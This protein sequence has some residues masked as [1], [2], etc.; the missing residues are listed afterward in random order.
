MRIRGRFWRIN[1]LVSALLLVSLALPVGTTLAEPTFVNN[2]FQAKW[3]RAD[4]P[5]QDGTVSP[6]RSWLWGPEGFNQPGAMTEPYAESPGGTRQVQYFDKARMELNNPA[7]ANVTNGLLV[8]ELISGRL[9]TGDNTSLARKPADIPVAGDAVNNDG[10][11]YASLASVAS[12]NLGKPSPN[13]TGQPVGDT[14]DKA[15]KT[16]TAPQLAAKAM[17]AYFDSVLKHNIPNV[18]WNFLNQKGNVYEKGKLVNDQP[19][20]GSNPAAPWLDATGYP[21]TEAYWTRVTVGGTVKDVLVQAYQRR[22]LT[23]TPEN[24]AAFQVEMG[25][26]GRH[27]FTW[28]YSGAYD[29]PKTPVVTIPPVQS[30]DPP[31]RNCNNLPPS[32]ARTPFFCGPAGMPVKIAAEYQ[33]NEAVTVD[34]YDPGDHLVE[35]FKGVTKP[36]GQFEIILD[37]WPSNTPGM[38]TYKLKGQVSGKE[39]VLYIWLDPPVDKPTAF[40]TPSSGPKGTQFYVLGVG[41][42]PNEFVYYSVKCPCGTGEVFTLEGQFYNYPR[43]GAGGGIVTGFSVPIDY[44]YSGVWTFAINARDTTGGARAATVDIKVTDQ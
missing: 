6:A 5:V 44:Y 15:G 33:A 26:V 3:Q 23:F 43:V 37:S 38:W 18:F 19:V 42:K 20:L 27:Y 32:T 9:A 17:Y 36:G 2:Q 1:S 28:R 35:T 31:V 11:T 41:F 14:I 4:K 10:P 7:T 34:R 13:R 16:G 25:N 40:V 12:L 39:L 24:P 30:P 21:L 22:V 8:I 29:V